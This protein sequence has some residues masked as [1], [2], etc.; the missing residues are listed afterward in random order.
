ML[1]LD[2]I[3]RGPRG[4]CREKSA[5]VHLSVPSI[6]LLSVRIHLN[7]PIWPHAEPSPAKPFGVAVHGGSACKLTIR[8]ARNKEPARLKK[9][10]GS[11]VRLISSEIGGRRSSISRNTVFVLDSSDIRRYRTA[12]VEGGLPMQWR[13]RG[14]RLSLFLLL[15]IT[16]SAHAAINMTGRW[17]VDGSVLDFTQVGTALTQTPP[18]AG[19]PGP[20]TGFIDSATGAFTVRYVTSAPQPKGGTRH[21]TTDD[22]AVGIP[23]FWPGGMPARRD[24]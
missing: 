9:A 17:V 19:Q 16:G 8:C 20:R 15:G 18:T 11:R 2:W 3:P 1:R 22:A 5:A 21:A 13:H 6:A 24:L 4:P 23:G 14:A 7:Q 10:F 12:V